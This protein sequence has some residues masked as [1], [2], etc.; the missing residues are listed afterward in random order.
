MAPFAALGISPGIRSQEAVQKSSRPHP[1]AT[2]RPSH[3]S[4]RLIND[5]IAGQYRGCRRLRDRGARPLR[6]RCFARELPR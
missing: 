1:P 5:R 6:S 3:L 4:W 2:F